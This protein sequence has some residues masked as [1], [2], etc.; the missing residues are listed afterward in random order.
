MGLGIWV[1]WG[2]G[3]CCG[4]L[5]GDRAVQALIFVQICLSDV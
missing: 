1:L 5:E 2:V 4:G 3:I